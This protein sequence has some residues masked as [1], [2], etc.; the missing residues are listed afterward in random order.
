LSIHALPELFFRNHLWLIAVQL[1][2][3]LAYLLYVVKFFGKLAPSIADARA[4]WRGISRDSEN[5]D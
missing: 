2:A 5:P 3:F 4:E 1:I